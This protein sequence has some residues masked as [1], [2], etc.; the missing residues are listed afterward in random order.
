MLH[1]VFVRVEKYCAG[2]IMACCTEYINQAIDV[3]CAPL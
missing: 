1:C 2:S 3:F